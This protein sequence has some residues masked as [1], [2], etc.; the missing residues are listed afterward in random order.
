[1]TKAKFLSQLREKLQGLPQSDTEKFL[2]YY[3]SVPKAEIFPSVRNLHLTPQKWKPQAA[4]YSF[5]ILM[6][7][8]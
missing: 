4:I 8:C 7:I 1:M 2:E 3:A 5:R 6:L